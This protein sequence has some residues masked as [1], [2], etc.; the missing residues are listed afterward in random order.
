VTEKQ[1]HTA[2]GAPEALQDWPTLVGRAVDDITRIMQSE[3]QM[4]ETRMGAALEARLAN[5]IATLSIV[6]M[7]L[8]GA[9]CILCAGILLLHQWL[10]LWQSFGIAGA[11]IMLIGLASYAI[12]KSSAGL[13]SAES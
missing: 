7:I 3:A 8:C 1:S 13:A 11:G 2:N 4:L 10:P 6:A 9:V 12:M 5:A